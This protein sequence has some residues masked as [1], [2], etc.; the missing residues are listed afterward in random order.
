M[1]NKSHAV[2]AQRYEAADSLDDFPTPPW[3]TR[4]LIEHVIGVEQVRGGCCLEP[5]CGR[6]HMAKTLAPYFADVIASDVAA[7]GFGEQH[8]FLTFHPNHPLDWIITNPPFRLAEDFFHHGFSISRQG[9]AL[10]TRTVFLEGKGRLERIFSKYPPSI[11]AQFS[12]RVPMVKGRLDRRASTA[13]GYAWVIWKKPLADYTRLTWIPSCRK[14]LERDQDYEL[15]Y[16]A[17]DDRRVSEALAGPDA[18]LDLFGYA[19]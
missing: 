3:A 14:T 16:V 19:Q 4:A 15:A 5:A 7:Y 2:M 6:G 8:D 10:L 13:T 11:V 18:P 12:E 1:Q 17:L 9:V